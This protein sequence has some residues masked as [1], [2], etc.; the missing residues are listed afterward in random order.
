[1]EMGKQ[2]FMKFMKEI[3]K[4]NLGVHEKI[5]FK[6]VLRTDRLVKKLFEESGDSTDEL[7]TELDNMKK[8]L[9]RYIKTS[10]NNGNGNGSREVA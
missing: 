5:D 3:H 8:S 2:N 6:Y 4:S 1:M 9:Q 10:N 7:S